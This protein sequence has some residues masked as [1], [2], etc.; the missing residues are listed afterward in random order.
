MNCYDIGKTYFDVICQE[1]KLG[2]RNAD[3]CFGDKSKAPTEVI[4]DV[5]ILERLVTMSNARGLFLTPNQLAAAV[6]PNTTPALNAYGWMSYHFDLMGDKMPNSIEIHLEP[7]EI[8]EVHMEY[9]EFMISEGQDFL[10][11]DQF[12]SLWRNCFSYVK[13]REFK[14]VTGKCKTCAFL[15]I[16][17]RKYR[18]RQHRSYITWL[19]ALHRTAY[20][21]ERMAYAE[22]IIQACQ[23]RT[24]DQG[25]LSINTDG[26]AQNHCKLPWLG[27]LAGFADPLPQHIQGVLIHSKGQMMYRTYHNIANSVNLQIHTLLMSL[28][29]VL[30][31]DGRLPGTIY[32]QVDGGAENIGKTML[33]M[34]ELLVCKRLTMKVV[35]SRLLVGHT[36]C[37]NDGIFG[38]IWVKVRNQFVLSPQEYKE[39]IIKATDSA[40]MKT[41]V[42]D[43]FVLPD[44]ESYLKPHIDKHFGLFAKEEHTKHQFTFEAVDI[45]PH[46]PC[47]CKTTYRAFC[48]DQVVKI[49]ENEAAMC[50]IEAINCHVTT[51]PSATDTQPAGMYIL[52]SLPLRSTAIKPVGFVADSQML[53]RNFLRRVKEN[54]LFRHVQE[55]WELFDRLIPVNDDVNQYILSERSTW[56]VPLRDALFESTICDTATHVPVRISKPRI[57]GPASLRQV[58]STSSVKWSQRGGL[59]TRPKQPWI[60]DKVRCT[61][62]II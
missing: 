15:S 43:V 8:K 56:H 60:N 37:D 12:A 61:Y 49:I 50:G 27:N 21:G 54:N 38:R 57:E 2:Y 58:Y 9:M 34:C 48:R 26:M 39:W 44:Y 55:Q 5:S 14:A 31:D 7:I 30:D 10:Q 16:A 46:F 13:I 24:G 28:Q 47:G 36:H 1:I 45:S 51:E 62:S 18:G 42:I 17:R 53:Y 22:R 33:G 19:H 25:F 3:K 11:L 23:L 29:R 4:K 35:L 59:I 32:I 40:E 41:S 20:M 52:Q 6:I